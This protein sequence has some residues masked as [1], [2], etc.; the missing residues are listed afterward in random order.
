M[1][2]QE[3]LLT[4]DDLWEISHRPEN[5][6]KKFE[7]IDGVLYEMH[8]PGETHGIIVSQ[9]IVLL[10]LYVKARRL[11]RIT[12]ETAYY[13]D[14]HNPLSPD[15]AFTRVERLKPPVE[16][17][18]AQMPDL[19]IEVKSP[20]NMMEEL[21]QKSERYLRNGVPLVWIVQPGR[22]KVH[23]CTLGETEM[24][25]TI[26]GINDTLDGG[27]VIPDLKLPVR[28]IFDTI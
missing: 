11:G 9:L 28:D 25:V 6:G 20:E 16:G 17:Y 7:L 19:A 23:I 21:K 4:V 12:A 24:T 3:K 15:I 18:V 22:K 8:P 14:R 13:L 5:D 2:E 1:S 26:L 10:S 27:N